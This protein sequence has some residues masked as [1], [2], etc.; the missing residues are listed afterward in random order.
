MKG[1]ILAA[2]RGRRMKGLTE[3][4]PKCL[5]T[6]RGKSLLDWQLGAMQ[7]A[8]ID[9]IAIVTG[10]KRNC[11]N[12]RGLTEF[13]NPFWANTQMVSSLMYADSWLEAEPCIVSYSDIFYNSKAIKLLLQTSANLAITYDP[14][15]LTIWQKRFDDPLSDAETF[16]ISSNQLL[17]EIG[18]SPLSID[19]ISGQFMGLLFFR[20][21]GWK[22]V[23]RVFS[24]ILTTDGSK[25]QMTGLLQKV[26]DAGRVPI[27]AIPYVAEWG[28]MDS[29]T[30]LLAY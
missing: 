8:G 11:L 2:G 15:W 6:F 24:E 18:G 27:H 28:E 22:E 10:Y 4:Q 20:P 5:I 13:H 16:R 14:Y 23:S 21:E 12:T 7:D 19:D 26:I 29:P 25:L 30:D 9:D 1:I 3:E 17:V